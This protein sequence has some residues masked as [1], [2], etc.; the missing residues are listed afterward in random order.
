MIT[1][2]FISLKT[3]GLLFGNRIAAAA[4]W[5]IQ[6]MAAAYLFS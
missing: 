6:K 4:C 1:D 5:Y 3:I 2:W